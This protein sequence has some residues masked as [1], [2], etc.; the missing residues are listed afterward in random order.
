MILDVLV[1]VHV[2]FAAPKHEPFRLPF[3]AIPDGNFSTI[4]WST[5]SG[6][7]YC[8]RFDDS[9]RELTYILASVIQGS[10]IGPE[11]FIV[12]ASD[13]QPEHAGNALV[14]F[15]DDTHVIVPTINS[16]TSTSELMNVRT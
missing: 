11:S 8:T 13:L 15:A 2:L 9:I 14:K 1:E 5:F 12:T 10:A 4:G 3:G 16:D 7:S 6:H